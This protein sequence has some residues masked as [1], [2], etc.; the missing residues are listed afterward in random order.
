[1]QWQAK[2]QSHRDHGK[3]LV[4]MVGKHFDV[5]RKNGH[6]QGDQA[7]TRCSPASRDQD[8]NSAQNFEHAT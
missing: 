5:G 3:S 6:K 2:K 7:L 8:A 1:L 4:N